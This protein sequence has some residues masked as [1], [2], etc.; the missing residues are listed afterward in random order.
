MN[1]EIDISDPKKLAKVRNDL[2]KML[3]IVDF[4]IT[5]HSTNR[6]HPA[7]GLLPLPI[8]KNGSDFRKADAPILE[9]LEHLANKFTTTDIVIGMGNEGK[10]S[11]GA[12]KMALKRAIEAGTV[13]LIQK[14]QGRRPSQY[15]KTTH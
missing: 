8:A 6:H 7:D 13:R 3:T 14:G 1:F 11:R 12:I 5:Q 9:V 15:E 10:E 2:T 4:A